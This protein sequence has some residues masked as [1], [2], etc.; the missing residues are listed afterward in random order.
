M[1]LGG[2][3]G[4]FLAARLHRF[5]S[6]LQARHQWLMLIILVTREAETRQIVV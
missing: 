6:Q 1:D 3:I 2:N 5:K 4:K